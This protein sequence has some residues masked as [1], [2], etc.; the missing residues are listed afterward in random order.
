MLLK[1]ALPS[2]E[3]PMISV[4]SAM[5]GPM[6]PMMFVS[7]LS[8]NQTVTTAASAMSAEPATTGQPRY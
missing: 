3:M 2:A 4:K 6:T 5:N 1:S 8:P 7:F